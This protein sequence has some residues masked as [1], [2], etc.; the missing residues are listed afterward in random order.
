MCVAL[1][2]AAEC[3]GSDLAIALTGSGAYL[4]TEVVDAGSCSAGCFESPGV[5]RVLG[6]SLRLFNVG[7][8]DAVLGTRDAPGT[9][10][11]CGPHV[12]N[13][14]IYELRAEDGTILR[15]LDARLQP[16]CTEET[17]LDS[18]R[19]RF[20]CEMLGLERGYYDDRAAGCTGLDISGVPE[21]RYTLAVRL[22]IDPDVFPDTDPSNNQ[23]ELPL[24]LQNDADPDPTVPCPEPG[25]LLLTDEAQDCGWTA[26]PVAECRPGEPFAVSC[27]ECAGEMLL[28]LC[29][30]EGPCS[31]VESI[32]DSSG[33]NGGCPV[34]GGTCPDS[35]TFTALVGPVDAGESFRC[36]LE[37]QYFEP[38]PLVPCS[39]S[40]A[41]DSLPDRDC[42]W[43]LGL[44]DSC[45]PGELVAAGCPDA[46]EGGP[47]LLACGG[48][49]PCLRASDQYLG[50]AEG[51]TDRGAPDS[52]PV[53]AFICPAE[54]R[55]TIL[56]TPG[57]LDST[58]T[59][60]LTRIEALA[61]TE[62]CSG[63][64]AAG[65]FTNQGC[66][67]SPVSDQ[68]CTPGENVDVQCALCAGSSDLRV[69]DGSDACIPQSPL[70]L[71]QDITDESCPSVS[72]ACPASGRYSAWV[73]AYQEVE[74]DVCRLLPSP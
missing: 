70:E 15:Q 18:A 34:A 37:L 59:C 29:S 20:S 74:T 69:C 58:F 4:S 23:L 22:E 41:N 46:C 54:G 10:L 61:P 49:E 25:E 16:G 9:F 30:G 19:T 36:D 3:P 32:D 45:A 55:Y 68:A 1:E 7:D 48:D 24:T 65:Y 72:F 27:P 6:V 14:L 50:M 38:D 51:H 35:G 26:S 44:T 33:T 66:G 67:W 60:S 12:A 42:S 13:G 17:P 56:A 63:G 47:V 39:E 40:P 11:G 73:F 62:P 8:V 64:I 2:P 71:G 57:D 21:G 43:T 52:C 5:R 28:R 31:S 53:V